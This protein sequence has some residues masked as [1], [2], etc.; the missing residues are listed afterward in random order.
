[1]VDDGVNKGVDERGEGRTR[2]EGAGDRGDG[3]GGR[4]EAGGDGARVVARA[5]YTMAGEVPIRLGVS[6]DELD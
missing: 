1:M 4:G 6:V 3:G 5:E 2:L